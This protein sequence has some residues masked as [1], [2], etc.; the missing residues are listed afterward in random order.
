MIGDALY[1]GRAAGFRRA[2]FPLKQTF[3]SLSPALENPKFSAA[4]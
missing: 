3:G 2:E 4:S 1:F